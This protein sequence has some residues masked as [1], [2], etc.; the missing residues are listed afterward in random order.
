MAMR[1][2]LGRAGSGKSDYC[3][4][5]IKDKLL[6]EPNGR[7]LILLVPEQATSLAEYALVS[8][9]ELG[10]TLRAQVLSFRRLAWRVMQE[11]GGTARLPIDG[12]GKILLLHKILHKHRDHL[13]LFHT[14]MDQMGFIEKIEEL[15]T[16]FKRYCI[17]SDSLSEFAANA[18]F[19]SMQA[20]MLPDKLHDLQLLYREF[21][22]ELSQAYLDGED[23]LT[24]LAEQLPHSGYIR[25]AECWIDGFH[26]FTPQEL[27]I[28]EGLTSHC[29]SVTLTLTLDREYRIGEKLHDLDLFHP[30]ARTMLQL[31]ERL[32]RLQLSIEE[33]LI[34]PSQPPVRFQESPMLAYMETTFEQRL[35]KPFPDGN[36]VRTNEIGIRLSAAVSRRAE[37]EGTA[38]DILR[39]VREGRL[40]Y[41]E[42]AVTVRNAEGYGP[43]LA[44]TF[45]DFGIPHFFDQKRSVMDHPLVEL[46]RSAMDVIL[47]YWK[48]DAVFRCVK[49]GFFLPLQSENNPDRLDRH[50]MDQLENYVLAFG[51]QG[52]R[53]FDGKP[54]TYSLRSSLERPEAEVNEAE[55]AFMR[56]IHAGRRRVAEPLHLF[57][58]EM[59][60]SGR[61]E[62]RVATLFRLLTALQVPDRLESWSQAAVQAG[63]T[64]KAREHAQVWDRI[65]DMLDQ[66][67]EIMGGEEVST[68]AFARLLETGMESIKLGLVPPSL[69]QVLIGSMDRTRMGSVKH[70]FVL[71]VNDGV[72]P[73][74][75]N[76]ESVLSE[77]ERE[78]LAVGGLPMAEDSR[79]KLLDE[80][81]LIYSAF[82]APSACLWLSYP[83]ADEEGKSLLPSDVIRHMK[84][85]FPFVRE[86]LLLNEP[87]AQMSMTE[88]LDYVEH[89][90]KAMS[91]LI[92]QLKQWLRGE[93]MSD[94]WWAVYNWF[95][96]QPGWSKRLKA[97][98]QSLLYTNEAKP[99][100]SRMSR[101]L[102]GDHVLTS[103]SRMERFV[104]CPFSQFASHGLR[105]QERRIYR[106]EAPDIG[107]LF[108]AALSMFAAQVV[109]RGGHWSRLTPEDCMAIAGDAV[110]LLAPRLQSEILFSSKRHHYI[111]RKL[112]QVVGR[113]AMMLGEHARR[114]RFE[115]IGLEIGFGADQPIPPLSYMLEN[116]VRMDV[117][118][119]IDRVDRADTEQGTLLRVIDY[120]SSPTALHLAE[121]FY[122]LSLQML[123]YLDVILTHSKTWLGTEA[124]PAGVLYFHVHNPL[125]QLKNRISAEK[126]DEELRKRFKMRGLVRADA[127][128]AQLMD[129][130]LSESSG[131][132]QL[133]PVALKADGSFYKSSSVADDGQWNLLRNYVRGTIKG[134]GSAMT[135]GS[136]NIEPYRMGT[137]AACTFCSFKPVCHF[138]TQF[139]ANQYKVLKPMGKDRAMELMASRLEPKTMPAERP[140]SPGTDNVVQF[141]ASKAEDG[142]SQETGRGN[143]FKPASNP[144]KK[145]GEYAAADDTVQAGAEAN[146]DSPV[147]AEAEVNKG[148]P[149][150]AET[151]ANADGPTPAGAEANA[152]GT[153]HADDAPE[154]NPL[155][156]APESNE[157]RGPDM[158]AGETGE[159]ASEQLEETEQLFMDF[160][161]LDGFAIESH[162]NKKRARVSNK[163]A[164]NSNEDRPAG[165]A[166]GNGIRQDDWPKSDHRDLAGGAGLGEG[167][168]TDR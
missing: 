133:I 96:R 123:T 11:V 132:S 62:H 31:K 115:P 159:L 21:E 118:G 56:L 110:D 129:S 86:R 156:G 126:A 144:A 79:R 87:A 23:Y 165:D 73:A 101:L 105:L 112:K 125:L 106:L 37:V 41:R 155:L 168:A 154:G 147:H 150:Q 20:A 117:R 84:R 72:I 26:G 121:V 107:Q 152:G 8:S 145:A 24:L 113:A 92:V 43:L 65:I 18:S 74:K 163:N 19:S 42:I 33:T 48:Y 88:Q 7:P 91:F 9:P 3:L 34:L 111:T 27:A 104:A 93:Q 59:K 47:H 10:G 25:D 116:G 161:E 60:Q 166:R 160:G 119:R 139:E 167:G 75:M 158:N 82:C 97:L 12:T 95:I 44:M 85:L 5:S 78:T 127:E 77:Q 39:L 15:F 140:E 151:E 64:E 40:R 46:I 35:K 122:G 4:R 63:D 124:K 98:M 162:P 103:V 120:K 141:R 29:N 108:H 22:T 71:G 114:G 52:A 76:E 16:E 148:R 69:D 94:V 36:L 128:T 134:I 157:G 164:G 32:D 6:K 109:S 54:W 58:E 68:E 2:V 138:D 28:I 81:F 57:Q 70:V 55:A 99:L 153:V 136:V 135:G 61:V 80:Q 89:P 149:V 49:T 137:E 130:A 131:H 67:V 53:W 146:T 50:S 38:R 45:A 51:I 143:G 13:K 83:L 30:P 102:Y 66:L 100:S 17:S 1:F 14:S 142:N 90:A